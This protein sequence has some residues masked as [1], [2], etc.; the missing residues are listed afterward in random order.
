VAVAVG[1]PTTVVLV[2]ILTV[3]NNI[4]I[5]NFVA[6]LVLGRT[7]NLH[8]AVVLLAA[9]VG[10]AIGGLVGLFLIVPSIAIL[11]A[12]WRSIVALFEPDAVSAGPDDVAGPERSG[13]SPA[14]PA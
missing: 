13:M 6:P 8:P 11:G 14:G 3:V 9:P 2:A 10:A 5:G 12:T 1:G 4:V 7:V